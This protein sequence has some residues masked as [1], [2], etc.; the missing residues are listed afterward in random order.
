MILAWIQIKKYWKQLFILLVAVLVLF[1]YIFIRKSNDNVKV[2]ISTK[3]ADGFREVNSKLTEVSHKAVIEAVIARTKHEET[4]AK[5]KDISEIKD[6]ND[7][8]TK[9][10]QMADFM[11][12]G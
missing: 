6:S 2:D 11:G 7:R 12:G 9:L 4:K 1:Y 8:R 3:L 10:A 5:L